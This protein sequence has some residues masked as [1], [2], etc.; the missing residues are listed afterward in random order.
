MATIHMCRRAPLVALPALVLA[1]LVLVPFLHKAFTIDDPLFLLQARHAIED[2]VHPTAFEMAWDDAFDRGVPRRAASISG[3][4][5][6]WL[7]VPAV[8]ADG[9][10][11]IAHCVQF[12]FLAIALFATAALARRIAIPLTWSSAAC[13]LVATAPGVLGMAGTVMPDVPGMALGVAGVERLIAWKQERR[14][15]Q[16]VLASVCLGLATLTRTHLSLL[17][18]VGALFVA[19]DFHEL[20]TWRNVRPST[21]VPLFIAPLITLGVVLITRDPAPGAGAVLGV[22]PQLR[23]PAWIPEN[24][25]A[26]ATHWALAFPLVI[27]WLT[28]RFLHVLRR[29]WVLVVATVVAGAVLYANESAQLPIA[30][31]A[32][33][34]VAV[35]FDIFAD[36]WQRRD[37]VQLALS[38]WLLVPLAPAVYVHL[39]PK[40]LLAAAPSAALLV[41]R[42]MARHGGQMPRY[43]FSTTAALGMA[44]GVAILRADA[45]FAEL[46]RRAA[47]EMIAPMAAA[48]HRVWFVGSWGFYWYADKAGA[49]PVTASPPYPLAGDMVVVSRRSAPSAAAFAVLARFPRA[50][51]VG[52]IE[53]RRPGGRVMSEE[54]GAGFYSN[55][56]GYLPWGWG[57]DVLDRFD[58]WELD[59]PAGPAR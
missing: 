31:V 32:G 16:A 58:L 40:Y 19:G 3:P 5:M 45:T 57:A 59:A 49:R 24:T 11:W 15:H 30:I 55:N 27:P 52:R 18:V 8:L 21:W 47:T 12:V 34:S 35:L 7:L 44:L 13:V 51:L 10:E 42:M 2:P 28:L 46:G 9:A 43:L 29:W 53:E 17:I 14:I 48:G 36:G 54:A 38:V 20:A 22:P 25:V 23:S 39:P 37:M 26:F 33:I 56:M 50:T 1:T 41:A 6:A 4:L